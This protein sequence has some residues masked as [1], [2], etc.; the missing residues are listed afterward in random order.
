MNRQGGDFDARSEM[1][2]LGGFVQ[3]ARGLPLR[4]VHPEG[5]D[6]QRGAP[7]V[8][9]S[10]S[11]AVV[12]QGSSLASVSAPGQAGVTVAGQYSPSRGG[13]YSMPGD[14]AYRANPHVSMTDHRQVASPSRLVNSY[15]DGRVGGS[16]RGLITSTMS[17]YS[18]VV[19]NSRGSGSSG[20]SSN[21]RELSPRKA[22][23]QGSPRNGTV[24]SSKEEYARL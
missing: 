20:S 13:Q 2:S 18:R 19:H 16:P 21:L 8:T 15:E 23:L 6:Q 3:D 14:A 22:L 17:D 24:S 11:Q 10:S 5:V 9:E 1:M 7:L 12:S 4:V